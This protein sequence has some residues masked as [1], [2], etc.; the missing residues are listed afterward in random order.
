V[1]LWRF[2]PPV[3]V[4]QPLSMDHPLWMRVKEKQPSAVVQTADGTWA[5]YVALPSTIDA[6]ADYLFGRT[7]RSPIPGGRGFNVSSDPKG[8]PV[9]TIADYGF[10]SPLRIYRGG[11]VYCIDDGLRTELL[12]AVTTEAPTGYGAYIV[13]APGG[14]VFTGDEIIKSG[15]TMEFEQGTA[16][17][18]HS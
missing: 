14:S 15:R 1:S 17:R 12:N 8:N 18:G 2:D 16:W 9:D 11:H 4:L 6:N 10:Q 3:R 5:E 13:A 7:D